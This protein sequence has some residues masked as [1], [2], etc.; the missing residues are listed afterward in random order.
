MYTVGYLIARIDF[1]REC[2][3]QKINKILVILTENWGEWGLNRREKRM[4]LGRAKENQT[5][6]KC[7]VP[8][9]AA[10]WK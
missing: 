2:K 3:I 6:S 8:L 5:S 4:L 10:Y 7:T 1:Y 9:S